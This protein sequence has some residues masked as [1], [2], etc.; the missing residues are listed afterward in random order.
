MH[1]CHGALLTYRSTHSIVRTR[2]IFKTRRLGDPE[3]CPNNE[4]C[5]YNAGRG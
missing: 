2:P 1:L 5:S 4:E 3:E